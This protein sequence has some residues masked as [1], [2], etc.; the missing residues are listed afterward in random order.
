MKKNNTLKKVARGMG[1]YTAT[2][3]LLDKI[4]PKHNHVYDIG[5]YVVHIVDHDMRPLSL[6]AET[7][8]IVGNNV[9]VATG[10]LF[11]LFPEDI[12][13]CI[14]A[15]EIGHLVLEGGM[16]ED[17]VQYAL[18]RIVGMCPKAEIIADSMSVALYGK[19]ATLKMLLYLLAITLSP[20]S[21]TRM[22]N[23]LLSK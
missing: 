23:V 19:K 20:E 7:R 4:L 6:V 15:H 16:P 1:R 5:N 17:A 11:E 3:L 13:K 9:H 12:R 22:V 10:G 2:L 21:L 14:L 18:T 8:A